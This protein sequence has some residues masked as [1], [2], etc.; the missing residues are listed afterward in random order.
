MIEGGVECGPNA[1]LAFAREGY[2][3][4]DVNLRDLVESLTYPGF[5]RLA[6]KYWRTGCGEMWRSISKGAFVRA[7]QALVPEIRAEHLEPAPAGVRAQ[8]LAR[9]GSM[10]DDFLIESS[11]RI[12]N[13]LNAPSPAATSSL[14]IGASIVDRIAERLSP[15]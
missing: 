5:L 7:L 11:D 8:S 12:V 2:H 13:V 6:A 9:D 4:T 15:V 14:L 3:K 1:V 10:V